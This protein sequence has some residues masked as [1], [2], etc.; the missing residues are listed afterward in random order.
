MET[1]VER[2]IFCVYEDLP[3]FKL[4]TLCGLLVKD[5][6]QWNLLRFVRSKEWMLL[7][8]DP[9]RAQQRILLHRLTEEFKTL[10]CDFYVLRPCPS[11]FFNLSVK[12]LQS[13]LVGCLLSHVKDKHTGE[14][15]I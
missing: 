7:H 4:Q 2:G 12:K 8:F 6:V 9:G 5:D 13:H 3:V 15:L 14:H 11:T 1:L 10:Q